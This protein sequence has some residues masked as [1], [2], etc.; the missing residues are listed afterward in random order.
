M[1]LANHIGSSTSPLLYKRAR[2]IAFKMEA[3]PILS[4]SRKFFDHEN[5]ELYTL[6]RCHAYLYMLKLLGLLVV[7]GLGSFTI[8]YSV[9]TT[10]VLCSHTL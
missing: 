6:L 3:K 7:S 5:L 1:F 9:V 8:V 4:K 2:L 10:P